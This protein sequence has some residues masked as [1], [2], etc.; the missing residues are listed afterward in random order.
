MLSKTKNG[1]YLATSPGS[2][3]WLAEFSGNNF[4]EAND[5]GCGSEITVLNFTDDG[6]LP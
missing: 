5:S 2:Y 4:N 1:G 6:T 3:F